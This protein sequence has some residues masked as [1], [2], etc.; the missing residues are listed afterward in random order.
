MSKVAFAVGPVVF[1]RHQWGESNAI[2][3]RSAL[4]TIAV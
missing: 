2:G 4:Q 3:E 1:L